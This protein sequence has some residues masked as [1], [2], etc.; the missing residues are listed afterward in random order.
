MAK[1][2]VLQNKVEAP[3]NELT[4]SI[5]IEL[6]KE[7]DK[8]PAGNTKIQTLGDLLCLTGQMLDNAEKYWANMKEPST[9]RT[10]QNIAKEIAFFL[11]KN[12]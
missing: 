4:S 7:L 9:K 11:S 2:L 6:Q 1:G 8:N 12:N 3:R 5:L 10:I